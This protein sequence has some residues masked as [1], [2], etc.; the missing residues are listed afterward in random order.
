MYQSRA[1]GRIYTEDG[2]DVTDQRSSVAGLDGAPAREDFEAARE[3]ADDI[4]ER[5]RQVERYERT[6]L[7]PAEERLRDEDDPPSRE[8]LEH[9]RQEIETEMP[10]DIAIH[11]E[12][13][14]RVRA[15]SMLSAADEYTGPA[16]L[17]VR[18]LTR[19]FAAA[20]DVSS[21]SSA[22]PSPTNAPKLS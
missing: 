3:H 12:A 13:P 1:D 21:D 9:D 7:S 10:A 2:V 6:V 11:Y 17:P 16:D 14:R 22:T 20:R 19:H 18:Y 4:A 15:P 5:Q 8:Q